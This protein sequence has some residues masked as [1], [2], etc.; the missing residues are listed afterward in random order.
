MSLVLSVHVQA[1]GSELCY[2]SEDSRVF[3]E[4]LIK[5]RQ[6]TGLTP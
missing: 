5:D 2:Q 4:G 6:V 3:S 1:W